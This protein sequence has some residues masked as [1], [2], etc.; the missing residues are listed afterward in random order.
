MKNIEEAFRIRGKMSSRSQEPFY[1][2]VTWTTEN[3]YK[4]VF[5]LFCFS[6]ILFF[7]ESNDHF[8]GNNSFNFL[9]LMNLVELCDIQALQMYIIARHC[10]QSGVT[11][12]TTSLLVQHHYNG[13][14]CREP[15][16]FG[17]APSTAKEANPWKVQLT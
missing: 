13:G 10:L 5:C 6:I 3:L 12:H 1:I 8:G 4:H 14:S 17:C 9:T 16:C 7:W 11:K 2:K 15:V